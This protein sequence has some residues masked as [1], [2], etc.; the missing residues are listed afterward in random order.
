MQLTKTQRAIVD[1]MFQSSNFIDAESI[2][3]KLNKN[4]KRHS[5]STVYASVRLL[6]MQG[7]L[8]AKQFERKNYFLLNENWVE[9]NYS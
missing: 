4:R 3:L 5:Y 2:F 9:K 1:L 8:I 6:H 7:I